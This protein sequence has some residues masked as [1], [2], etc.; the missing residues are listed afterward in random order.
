MPLDKAALL[1]QLAS[2]T[3]DLE[4]SAGTSAQHLEQARAVVAQAIAAGQ[5]E[6]PTRAFTAGSALQ[7]PITAAQ[8][9]RL[10]SAADTALAQPAQA[11]EFLVARREVPLAAGGLASLTPDWAAGR[12]IDSTLGPFRDALGRPV[13]IDVFKIVR[14]IRLVRSPGAAP[15]LTVPLQGLVIQGDHFTLPAGSVWLAS[16]QIAPSAPAGSYTGLLIRGGTLTFSHPLTASG[17]EIIVPPTVTCTLSLKLNPGTAP[18]GAGA[19]E[20][21]RLAAADLPKTVTFVFSSAGARIQSAGKAHVK[22]YGSGLRLIPRRTR[23]STSRR[24]GASSS[25]PEPM[26]TRSL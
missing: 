23:P 3:A 21:A 19:G 2:V 6:S 16:P 8:Q 25:R 15:F 13:W 10:E 24:S 17:G 4:T 1:D 5:S 18:S 26:P 22:V 12:A 20:D 7:P 9:A 11:P 14:Q